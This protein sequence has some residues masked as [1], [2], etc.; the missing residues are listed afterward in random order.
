MEKLEKNEMVI[1]RAMDEIFQFK[2]R[3]KLMQ[4]E[5]KRDIEDT[6]DFIKQVM[7]QLKENLQKE[8]S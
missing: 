6:A 2:E 8:Y 5:R 7:D 1:E 4:D 3:I